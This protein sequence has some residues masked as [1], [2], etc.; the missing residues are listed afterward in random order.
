MCFISKPW[1]WCLE[2]KWWK[3]CSNCSNTCSPNCI[4]VDAYSCHGRE[5]ESRNHLC[6]KAMSET[7]THTVRLHVWN[8]V[9][10]LPS[11]QKSKGPTEKAR[12]YILFSISDLFL[13]HRPAQKH[14]TGPFWRDRFHRL[15]C[16]SSNKGPKICR[17]LSDFL[18][19]NP[20]GDG[21]NDLFLLFPLLAVINWGCLSW[22]L[23]P[24]WKGGKATQAVDWLIT[25]VHSM[26]LAVD[27]HVYVQ[28][29]WWND[30]K[31]K[32]KRN[33]R[34]IK[35]LRYTAQDVGTLLP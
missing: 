3:L 4:Q 14:R 12:F 1:W 19:F 30:G 18:K 21:I 17:V 22:W 34:V 33:M 20:R 31:K 23:Y 8:L 15:C 27:V 26:K 25:F 5:T 32:K 24:F 2:A 28:P 11:F 13:L 10:S 7:H 6:Q 29:T 9:W 35:K 16:S